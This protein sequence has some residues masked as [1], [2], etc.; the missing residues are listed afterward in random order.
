MMSHLKIYAPMSPKTAAVTAQA[1]TATQGT[2]PSTNF[3]WPSAAPSMPPQA[4]VPGATSVT[5]N[6]ASNA[7]VEVAEATGLPGGHEA[8]NYLPALIQCQCAS[9]LDPFHWRYRNFLPEQFGR[10]N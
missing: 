7:T 10:K 1:A 8:Q 2:A 4:T 3:F 6:P 5:S 9:F